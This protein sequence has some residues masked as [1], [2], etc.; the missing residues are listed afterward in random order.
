MRVTNLSTH[1]NITNQIRRGAEQLFE[2]QEKAATQRRI[3]R[4]SDDPIGAGQLFSVRAALEQNAQFQRNLD[5]ATGLAETYD[6]TLGEVVDSLSRAKELLLSQANDISASPQTREAARVEM[7][8]LLQEVLTASNTARLGAKFIFAGFRDDAPAFRGA[9]TTTTADPGNAPGGAAVADETVFDAVHFTGDDYRIEFTGAATF[10]IFDV[11]QGR[12]IS[13]GNA[14]VSAQPIRFDGIAI[15]LSDSPGAP[16][17]GDVFHVA[18]TEAGEYLGDSGEQKLELEQGNR[19]TVNMTGEAVFQGVGV[20]GGT[21]IFD[22]LNRAVR[23]LREN[24]GAEIQSLIDEVDSAVQQTAN[25]QAVA[26][27]RQNQIKAIG[28]RLTDLQT[29]LETLQSDLRD[30]DMAEA[31]TT[32]SQREVAYEASLGAA[33]RV[34]MPTLLD[35]LR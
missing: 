20:A 12:Y 22:L 16:Q 3:N 26:G 35:F 5:Y 25:F 8:S 1:Y 4:M 32:L 27:T 11:T 2:A 19:V 29:S 13:T 28:T 9:Y 7:V 30:V 31:L 15:T 10:D 23:A 24:D 14:Y 21:N 34:I 33:S 18:S 17:A 6:S